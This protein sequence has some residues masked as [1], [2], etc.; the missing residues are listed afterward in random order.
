MRGGRRLTD[1]QMAVLDRIVLRYRH[2]IPDFE[3]VAPEIGINPEQ[4]EDKE[5]GPLLA[6][7]GEVT[8]FA[9]AVE[10]GK[11]VWSDEEF[12]Q[13]L[14]KQFETRKNLSPK[15][16]FSLRRLVVRYSTKIPGYEAAREALNLPEPRA[17]K[18]ATGARGR[19]G[20]RSAPGD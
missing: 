3:K 16:R 9:P 7:M 2:Q 14:K 4:V 15:Q 17:A 5:S 18:P 12:Y 6:L 8:E 19:K 13:S 20:R 10:R 11:R 1:N